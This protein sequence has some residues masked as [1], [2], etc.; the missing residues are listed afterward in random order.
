M[1]ETITGYTTLSNTNF[2]AQNFK[3]Q[4]EMA[5]FECIK[6]IAENLII[7][8]IGIRGANCIYFDSMDGKRLGITQHLIPFQTSD[9]PSLL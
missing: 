3:N 7:A 5:T 1:L 6:A 2:R 9:P 8:Q 4:D